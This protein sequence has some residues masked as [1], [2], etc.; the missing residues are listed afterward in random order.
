MVVAR[1]NRLIRMTDRLQVAA[2]PADKPLAE[3]NVI[4]FRRKEREKACCSEGTDLNALISCITTQ[5]SRTK[6]TIDAGRWLQS[7]NNR[8]E[9]KK[10]RQLEQNF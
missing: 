8:K 5:C 9:R 7:I 1:R 3:R 2:Q 6:R 4:T 10:T